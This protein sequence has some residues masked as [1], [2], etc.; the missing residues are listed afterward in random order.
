MGL[1]SVFGV[2][3]LFCMLGCQYVCSRRAGLAVQG[4]HDAV[5]GLIPIE[6]YIETMKA[7]KQLAAGVKR[8][9]FF[10]ATDDAEAEAQIRAAF[11]PGA[12]LFFHSKVQRQQCG[13]TCPIHYLF[14]ILKQPFN[15]LCCYRNVP[16]VVLKVQN[17]HT[18]SIMCSSPRSCDA[19]SEVFDKVC[20]SAQHMAGCLTRESDL[21]MVL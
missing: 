6:T 7:Q 15:R 21:L 10:L 17:A 1:V 18:S 12:V 16:R 19:M 3:L 5:K 4:K 13:F 2:D 20:L 11:K 14:C 9:R 8:V